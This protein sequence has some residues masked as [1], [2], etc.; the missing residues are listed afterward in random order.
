MTEVPLFSVITPLH[1]P[2]NAFLRETYETL[3]AQTCGSWEWTILPNAGGVVPSDLDDDPRVRVLQDPGLPAGNIGALKRHLSMMARGTY[4]LELDADDLLRADAL[5]K[6]KEAFDRGADFVYSDFAEFQHGTWAPRSASYPYGSAF[7]WS[8]YPTSHLGHPLIAMIAPPATAHNLRRIEWAPNH[9]RAW[10]VESYRAVGGHDASRRVGDDHDLMVRYYLAGKRF[11][12][13]PE[14]LYFYRVH[15]ENTVRRANAAILAA[16]EAIYDRSILSLAEAWS[17]REKLL[18]VDLCGAHEAPGGYVI[19]DREPCPGGTVCD[20]DGPWPLADDSVG[21]LRASDAVE[22]LRDPVHTMN[23]AW[24]VLA[25]GGFMFVEVPSTNGAGAFCDPTH[26]SFWNSL[27]FRYY[28]DRR[29]ARYVPAFRGRFQV[30]RVVEH[31]P[32][33]WHREHNVPYAQ[34]HLF[35]LKGDFEAMGERLW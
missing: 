1:A 23:E 29:F 27:S 32:S 10:T 17:Q 25:P 20:L 34:A 33:A 3:R 13:V 18:C 2:G 4:V 30:S 22:H 11:E 12:C 26:V 9:L 15:P 24:R 28:T 31:Y 19:L 8:T 6:T 14:C 35:A 7:G 16:T 21:V 5:E